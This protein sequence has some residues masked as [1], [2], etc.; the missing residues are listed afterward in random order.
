VSRSNCWVYAN[1]L[2]E[3][4]ISEKYSWA[5]LKAWSETVAA[6][7][8]R[9]VCCAQTLAALDLCCAQSSSPRPAALHA[10][11]APNSLSRLAAFH[12]AREKELRSF[13]RALSSFQGQQST[14]GWLRVRASGVQATGSRAL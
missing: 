1:D 12:L 11:C 6:G 8:A 9:H 10:C 14:D 7:A 13:C 4:S 2:A 5:V 3:E